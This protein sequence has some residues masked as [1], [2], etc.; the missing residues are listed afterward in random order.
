MGTNCVLNTAVPNTSVTLEKGSDIPDPAAIPE[1][2]LL[3]T[4]GRSGANRTQ[5][6][7]VRHGGRIPC[8]GCP[9]AL[10]K[11]GSLLSPAPN[12]GALPLPDTDR[13]HLTNLTRGLGDTQRWEANDDLL[14]T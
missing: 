14:L 7:S 9:T 6:K 3:A 12:P 10:L 11:H 4:P 2:F 8:T 5:S 13:G 1:A